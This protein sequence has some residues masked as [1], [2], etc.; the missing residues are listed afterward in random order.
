MLSVSSQP[1]SRSVL[2]AY[3]PTWPIDRWLAGGGGCHGCMILWLSEHVW[4]VI[5]LPGFGCLCD[6]PQ[7]LSAYE[8]MLFNL[9]F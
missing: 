6:F 5:G 2:S 7:E 4:S 8:C 1:A 9:Y 3:L